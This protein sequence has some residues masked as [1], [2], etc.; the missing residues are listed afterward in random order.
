MA[1]PATITDCVERLAATYSRSQHWAGAT[2]RTWSEAFAST[3]SAVL[4]GVTKD[5]IN[6][7]AEAPR[8]AEIRDLIR[9]AMP[10][11]APKGC[12][13]CSPPGMVDVLVLH[14][15]PAEGRT[16][17]CTSYV[18]GCACPAGARYTQSMGQIDRLTRHWIDR[19]AWDVIE[20]PTGADRHLAETGQRL[21][22]RPDARIAIEA[23]R[24]APERQRRDCE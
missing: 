9:A 19:G 20:R 7:Q 6:Q 16:V 5:W 1:D 24:R 2:H 8:I 14:A 13:R 23:Q 22:G 4:L 11:Q 12:P 17:P 10:R 18:V 21:M 15:A 3:P